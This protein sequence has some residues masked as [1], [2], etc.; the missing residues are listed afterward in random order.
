MT[1]A[2]ADEFV[3]EVAPGVLKFVNE[4]A[5]PELVAAGLLLLLADDVPDAIWAGRYQVVEAALQ[6]RCEQ[7]TGT[8]LQTEAELVVAGMATLPVDL[9]ERIAARLGAGKAALKEARRCR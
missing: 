2:S 9:R 3:V 7:R 8:L 6:A 4:S 1:V 5:T